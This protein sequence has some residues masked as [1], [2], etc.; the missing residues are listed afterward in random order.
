VFP[1]LI[2][3]GGFYI[4]TYGFLVTTGVVLGLWLTL[5]LAKQEGMDRKTRDQ[6]SNVIIYT[7]IGGLLGSKLLLVVVDL[8]YY[9]AHPLEL[10]YILRAGGVFFGGLIGGIVTAVLLFRRYQLPFY[11]TADMVAPHLALGHAIGRLGCFSAGCCYGAACDAPFAVT[12]HSHFAHSVVGV[13]LETP[14]FPT[15]LMSAAMLLVVFLVTRF[16]IYPR[17][18]WDGQV[19]WSY[20]LLYSIGRFIIEFFRGDIAR[21]FVW[22]TLSTSQF[23]GIILA[24]LS[25][26]M[27]VRAW[28]KHRS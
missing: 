1:K 23:I 12:F 28:R 19:L 22:G 5:R 20:V 2:E 24:A 7:V 27:L 17:R 13:P 4:P 9:V 6:I 21:G 18:K 8:R 15:Q 16:V 3:I 11:R 25:A 10:V 26:G 14:L